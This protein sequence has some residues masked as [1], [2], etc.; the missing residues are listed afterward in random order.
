[1]RANT[2]RWAFVA[3]LALNLLL[4]GVT[5]TWLWRSDSRSGPSALAEAVATLPEPDRA[6]LGQLLDRR[7]A[8]ADAIWNDMR[9]LRSSANQALSADPYDP[10]KAA[11]AL[12]AVRDKFKELRD[13][14]EG[15]ALEIMP[16]LPAEQ[17]RKL[18][19]RR[20]ALWRL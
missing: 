8:E 10:D 19:E 5:G 16:K 14:V 1:M 11:A 18:L 17:R 4:L 13:V 15:T 12:A 7:R 2:W 20:S 9:R 6:T 3:S